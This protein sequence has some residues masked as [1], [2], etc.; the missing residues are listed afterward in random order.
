VEKARVLAARPMAAGE[1]VEL[2]EVIV[3][4]VV[5]EVEEEGSVLIRAGIAMLGEAE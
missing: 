2:G 5:L 4:I 1:R 3:V